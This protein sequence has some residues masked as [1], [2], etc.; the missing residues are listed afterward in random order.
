MPKLPRR[1]FSKYPSSSTSN[2]GAFELKSFFRST[3]G[4]IDR[5]GG[6]IECRAAAIGT[7]GSAL[8]STTHNKS[9]NKDR[10][11]T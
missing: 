2:N 3:A 5:R 1:F 11:E 10:Q 9:K 8:Y 7:D 6:L 4:F